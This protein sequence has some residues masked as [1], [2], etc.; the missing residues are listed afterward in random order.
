MRNPLDTEKDVSER[1]FT[2]K[3]N[4]EMTGVD[5]CPAADAEMLENSAISA[6]LVPV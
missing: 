6:M 2:A 1:S 3:H 4:V 5:L